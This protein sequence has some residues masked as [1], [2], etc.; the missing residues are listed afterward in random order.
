MRR[1]STG[2]IGA[3][4][5][6]AFAAG[7]GDDDDDAVVID[8]ALAVDDAGR[9]IDSS[10]ST[11]DSGSTTVVPM[12]FWPLATQDVSGAAFLHPNSQTI[13]TNFKSIGGFGNAN[14]LKI[15]FSIQVLKADAT[16]PLRSFTKTA[17]FYDTEC[18]FTAIPIPA[19][20]QVEGSPTKNYACM[21]AGDCHLIVIHEPTNKLYES[22]VADISGAASTFTSG[23][24]AVWDMNRVYPLNG[25]GDRC[26]S[27][28]AAGYP[29]AP[30][31]FTA[32]EVKAG[33]INHAIRFILPNT[34]IQQGRYVHPATH[35]TSTTGGANGIIYGTR[36]RLKNDPAILARLPSDAARVVARAMQKYGMFLADGGNDALTAQHDRFNTA[37]WGARIQPEDWVDQDDP[38]RLLGPEDLYA[39]TPD[40]FEVVA[41]PDPGVSPVT[42]NAQ[43]DTC[44]RNCWTTAE[45][46]MVGPG[47][48]CVGAA[49]ANPGTCQ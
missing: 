14:R 27:A 10:T 31:L 43:N 47:L 49:G 20:G 17:N 41:V 26:T 3:L 40:D 37:K 29:I 5:L 28:D 34:R 8:A 21:D 6:L 23:C 25:R 33:A 42:Y 18:D 12:G 15:D 11:V 2:F 35:A 9:V 48:T 32:D 30:L 36:L 38:N 4:S 39:L 22:W 16:A 46:G 13:I 44:V 7:C 24:L 1:I 45:C 19:G